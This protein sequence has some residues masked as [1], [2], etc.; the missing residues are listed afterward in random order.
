MLA[1][2]SSSLPTSQ[3]SY[4]L[5]RY[6]ATNQL[7]LFLLVPSHL[8]ILTY[9]PHRPS[10]IDI[11]QAP[12][13]R[14][15]P[16]ENVV[17]ANAPTGDEISWGVAHVSTFEVDV[18]VCL[19]DCR[20]EFEWDD[21]DRREWESTKS[22]KNNDGEE[23]REQLRENVRIVEVEMILGLH[24]SSPRFSLDDPCCC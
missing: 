24:I 21:G 23:R 4:S 22:W 11:S 15:A 2:P 14:K 17:A 3:A 12:K 5:H 1:S 10:L 20:L 6:L 7:A 18:V 8:F 13:V 9:L 16:V 19:R